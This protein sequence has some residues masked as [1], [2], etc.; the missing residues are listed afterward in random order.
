M[1]KE[2]GHM[3]SCRHA[4][5]E[6]HMTRK[7]LEEATVLSKARMKRYCLKYQESSDAHIHTRARCSPAAVSSRYVDLPHSGSTIGLVVLFEADRLWTVG[8]G[9]RRTSKPASV[10]PSLSPEQ[11]IVG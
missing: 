8:S 6:G 10:V 4:F 9:F 1:L 3:F 5:R 11:R 2:A 7:Q